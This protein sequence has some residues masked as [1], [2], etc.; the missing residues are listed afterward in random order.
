[1]HIL[2][3]NEVQDEKSHL[4]SCDFYSIGYRAFELRVLSQMSG[5]D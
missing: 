3:M 2:W 1:M 4:L 5:E